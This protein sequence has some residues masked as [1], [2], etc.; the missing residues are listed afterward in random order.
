MQRH[1]T[2]GRY[3]QISGNG[4]NAIALNDAVLN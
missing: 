1:D 4:G 3:V 2:R